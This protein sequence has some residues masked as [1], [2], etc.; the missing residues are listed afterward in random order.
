MIE[1]LLQRRAQLLMRLKNYESS[2]F[3][4]ERT[5]NVIERTRR[6]IN[7]VEDVIKETIDNE[8]K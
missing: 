4:S 7:K 8:S 1:N 3:N 2:V 6:E 5:K